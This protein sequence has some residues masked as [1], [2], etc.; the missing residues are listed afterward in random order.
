[1]GAGWGVDRWAGS[2]TGYGV[3]VGGLLG[4]VLGFVAFIRS[5]L[6]LL[7]SNGKSKGPS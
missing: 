7:E 3:V 5:A 1:V 6:K 4:S 2:T